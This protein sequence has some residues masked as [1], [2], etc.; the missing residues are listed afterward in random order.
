MQWMVDQK[1][2]CMPKLLN[3]D[4]YG[5]IAQFNREAFEHLLAG[6]QILAIGDVVLPTVPGAGDALAIEL[7]LGDGASLV[8]AHS[9][10]G[11]Q[12][13]SAA[14]QSHDTCVDD[15]FAAAVRR[16]VG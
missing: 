12:P 14:K 8:G 6:Q 15:E 9:I 4:P 11:M 13:L 7:P 3:I 10:D 1:L 2:H 5:I 16:N